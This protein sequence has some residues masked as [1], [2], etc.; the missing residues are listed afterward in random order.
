M[1]KGVYFWALQVEGFW[2]RGP[3]S[4]TAAPQSR[5]TRGSIRSRQVYDAEFPRFGPGRPTRGAEPTNKWN[6]TAPEKDAQKQRK[7]ARG[8][9]E[10]TAARN[11]QSQQLTRLNET[12]ANAGQTKPRAT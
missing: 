1:S 8:A 4:R 3:A 10:T 7:P 2:K 5:Y 11:D 9:N 12:A 6:D